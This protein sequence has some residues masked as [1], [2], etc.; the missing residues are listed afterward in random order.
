MTARE[1]ENSATNYI[2]GNMSEG[3]KIAFEQMLEQDEKAKQKVN[4]LLLAWNS[5]EIST[6][7][8]IV[9]EMDH[10]F[11]SM[12]N[13]QISTHEASKIYRMHPVMYWLIST[14]AV[15][16]FIIAFFIG[17]NTASSQEIIKY[18]VAQIMKPGPV[19]TKVV[20]VYLVRNNENK[21]QNIT[22]QQAPLI[23]QLQSVYSSKRISAVLAMGHREL[24]TSY[25]KALD[26]ALKH[27]PDPNVQLAILQTLQ[28]KANSYE[29]QRLLIN[30]LPFVQG[31]VQSSMVDIL[32]EK[33]SK[34]AIPE[35]L[36]LLNDDNT[37][38]HTQG[39]IRLGIEEF[40][41]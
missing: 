19:Q 14:A 40:L 22:D 26:S 13:N 9:D 15:I 12:L 11:Y 34:E 33:K 32:L 3:E 28:P 4:E 27:D 25:L 16:I 17:K 6:D 35:M 20:K 41:N 5:L 18:R 36:T 39:Q 23:A 30:A 8:M 37:D 2:T 1:I 10:D 38:Y 24:N 29:V 21:K 31:T 7:P